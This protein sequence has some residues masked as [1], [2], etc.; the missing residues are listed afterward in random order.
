M[1]PEEDSFELFDQKKEHMEPREP[2]TPA[3]EEG[4]PRQGAD[5]DSR[6][7]R[8]SSAG[9]I[10]QIKPAK[11]TETTTID[12]LNKP[13]LFRQRTQRRL[14]LYLSNN[15][16]I[17]ITNRTLAEILGIGETTVRD[18]LKTFEQLGIIEKIPIGNRGLHIRFLGGGNPEIKALV[19]KLVRS[20]KSAPPPDMIDREENNSISTPWG[21]T[22]EF[23]KSRW[24][25]CFEKGFRAEQA[26]NAINA[27]V[28][29]GHNPDPK[30]FSVSLDRAEW[31][32]EN[33]CVIIDLKNNVKVRDSVSYIF[34]AL[35]R[36]GFFRAHPE[37]VSREETELSAIKKE[38]S[39]REKAKQESEHLSFSIWRQSL[40]KDALKTILQTN[41]LF[42]TEERKLHQFWTTKIKGKQS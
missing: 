5:F 32:L 1:I 8:E 33:K 40:S 11:S 9:K 39:L 14:L 21:W 23:I 34:T 26:S 7:R 3:E 17:M 25:I 19:A 29:L 42:N 18:N 38:I 24:P 31:E 15:R 6:I 12:L 20:Q 41:S 27:R 16:D 10:L 35:A 28:K 4:R 37:Y 22:D 30:I 2:K 36:W 13:R